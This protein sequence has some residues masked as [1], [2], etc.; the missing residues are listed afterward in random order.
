MQADHGSYF[1][2]M[3]KKAKLHKLKR[4]KDKDKD[5]IIKKK[6]RVLR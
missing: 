5:K 6:K 3:Y 1:I 4:K 2:T